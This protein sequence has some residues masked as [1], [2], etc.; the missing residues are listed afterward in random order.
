MKP[1]WKINGH[2]R[3]DLWTI[4]DIALHA[5]RIDDLDQSRYRMGVN[6]T[7]VFKSIPISYYIKVKYSSACS[8]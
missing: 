1:D 2:E 4:N 5:E 8:F 7:P 6:T 3:G